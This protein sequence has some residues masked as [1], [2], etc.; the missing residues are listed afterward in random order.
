MRKLFIVITFQGEPNSFIL[1][2]PSGKERK[3]SLVIE[4][5]TM[6]R[7]F[8]NIK[9]ETLPLKYTPN[10]KFWMTTEI[11]TKW[12]QKFDLKKGSRE[13]NFTFFSQRCLPSIENQIK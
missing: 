6:H 7:C 10:E 2:Q 8:K 3:A 9:I 5:S 1:Y 11:M 13:G 4:K 12:L